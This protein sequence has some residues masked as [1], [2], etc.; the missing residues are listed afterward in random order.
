MSAR[1]TRDGRSQRWL[2]QRTPENVA[3]RFALAD[4]GARLLA[5]GIDTVLQVVLVFVL[6]TALLLVLGPIGLA[7]GLVLSFVVRNFYFAGL[8]LSLRGATP[9]KR[10]MGLVVVSRDGGALTAE[11]LLARNLTREAELFVPLSAL[12]A[13]T[14]VFGDHPGSLAILALVAWTGVLLLFPALHPTG[15]RIGDLL[16]GTLVVSRPRTALRPDLVDRA[17]ARFTFTDDQ[18]DLYGIR[19]LQVLEGILR[20]RLG[21]TFLLRDVAQRIANKIGLEEGPPDDVRGFLEAF[22]A[23]QRARLEQ[24][25]IMGERRERKRR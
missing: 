10:V 20:D 17:S 9:G 24:R 21:E 5:F 7:V 14:V 23:A 18:L 22:Y 11:M 3:V 6:W 1:V 16:A 8:E 25:L 19:E 13:P 2:H 15:A 12:A 4:P